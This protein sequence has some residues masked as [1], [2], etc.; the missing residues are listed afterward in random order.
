MAKMHRNHILP[1]CILFLAWTIYANFTILPISSQQLFSSHYFFLPNEDILGSVNSHTPRPPVHWN[2]SWLGNEWLPNP[3]FGYRLYSPSEIKEYFTN[4]SVLVIGD[5]TSRRQFA[6]WYA[7]LNAQNLHDI[8]LDEVTSAGVIDINKKVTTEKAEEGYTLTRQCPGG[9]RCDLMGTVCL[10]FL[11]NDLKTESFLFQQIQRHMYSIVLFVMGPWEYSSRTECISL[12]QGRRNSTE[13]VISRL[14]EMAD[15]FPSTKFIWRTW[16]GP[17]DKSGDGRSAAWKNAQAHNHY[18]KTLIHKFQKERF[19]SNDPAWTQISYID[20]GHAMGPRTFP[21]RKRIAGDIDNHFGFEARLAFVHM[22]MNHMNEL[23]RAEK[24]NL[25]PGWSLWNSSD[26]ANDCLHAGGSPLYCLSDNELAVHYKS[27]LTISVPPKEMN[28]T[29]KEVYNRAKADYCEFCPSS[30]GG[31]IC[32]A[33]LMYLKGKYGLSEV[34]A[35]F[36]VVGDPACN[37]SSTKTN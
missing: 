14:V 10:Q 19:E 15:Q 8:A 33:R 22:W 20:W 23:E 29:E 5:S 26:S 24:Q 37:K 30:T 31:I 16:A 3:A 32:N 13:E 6:T 35:L 21:N 25:A 18:I 1:L 12:E 2:S 27:F 7:I 11:V 34:D 4:K 36:A 17:S 9:K 28:Q